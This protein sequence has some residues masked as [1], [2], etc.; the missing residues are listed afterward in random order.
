MHYEEPK[1]LVGTI[2]VESEFLSIS[3]IETGDVVSWTF[4]NDDDNV[5]N[6]SDVE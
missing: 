4:E 5:L 1:M 2:D 6:L 3:T